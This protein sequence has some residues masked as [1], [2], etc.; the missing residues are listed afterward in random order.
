MREP[1][2]DRWP[3]WPRVDVLPMPEPMPRPTR[4]RFSD[5]FFGARMLDRFICFASCQTRVSKFQGFRVSK[6]SPIASDFET[7][8]PW[9]LET[10]HYD[11]YQMRYLLHHAANGRRIR[12]LNHLVQPGKS[13]PL[14]DQLMLHRGADRR[15]HILDL[16][17]PAARVCFFC[18]NRVP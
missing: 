13:Q 8:K 3:L 2:R 11:L 12:T 4:L 17:R 6:F 16:D 18:H 7:L 14:H 10:S 15:P 9:H 5:A 1:L